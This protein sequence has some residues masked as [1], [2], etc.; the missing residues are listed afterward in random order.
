MNLEKSIICPICGSYDTELIKWG[1][2]KYRCL[3]CDCEFYE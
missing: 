1:E 3:H 2:D